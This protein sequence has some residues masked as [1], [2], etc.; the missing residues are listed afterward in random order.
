MGLKSSPDSPAQDGEAIRRVL[1]R[2]EL[3]S[4][5]IRSALGLQLGLSDPEM[6]VLAHLEYRDELTPSRL[7]ALLDL[8]SGGIT[9]LLQRLERNG[10]VVREPHPTD[11]RSCVIRPT[12]ETMRRG[13]EAVV[14]VTQQVDSLLT[15]LGADDRRL[16]LE[17]LERVTRATERHASR[18]WRERDD[19]DDVPLRPVPSLWA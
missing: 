10:H 5:R 18:M 12:S 13:T 15:S 3:A 4:S 16:I 6:L 19:A 14:P 9:A 1:E 11:R 17:F 8:S 2:R 7:G